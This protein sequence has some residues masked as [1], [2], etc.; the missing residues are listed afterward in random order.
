MAL[1]EGVIG[2]TQVELCTSVTAGVLFYERHDNTE[3]SGVFH[4]FFVQR[5]AHLR[6]SCSVATKHD[7]ASLPRALFSSEWIFGCQKG[8]YPSVASKHDPQ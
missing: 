6:P 3:L 5:K 8:D 4:P 1:L 2:V 7:E